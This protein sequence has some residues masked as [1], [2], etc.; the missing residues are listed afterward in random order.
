M[1][2]TLGILLSII[3]GAVIVVGFGG[4]LLEVVDLYGSALSDPMNDA[5]GQ[6]PLDEPKAVRNAMLRWIIIGGA[7]VPFS[8]LGA[9]LL[10]K[11]MR[12]NRKRSS[13]YPA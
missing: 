9:L 6:S 7:G 10:K 5:G 2:L 11:S 13:D 1:K 3:G 12:Q 8:V 4:A